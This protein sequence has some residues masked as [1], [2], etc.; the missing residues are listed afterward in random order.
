MLTLICAITKQFIHYI[1]GVNVYH[2]LMIFYAVYSVCAAYKQHFMVK[3]RLFYLRMMKNNSQSPSWVK[4]IKNAKHPQTICSPI[5]YIIQPYTY[6]WCSK[7]VIEYI[8]NT[9][10]GCIPYTCYIIN[11]II[12]ALHFTA[13]GHLWSNVK[14]H[15]STHLVWK[16]H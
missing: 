8:Q 10:S 12:L 4:C 9:S 14:E 3:Y 2:Q 1:R 16:E 11:F 7:N 13:D 5:Q 6:S 15:N